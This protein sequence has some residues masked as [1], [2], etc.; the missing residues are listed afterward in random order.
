MG[1]A[2]AN[3]CDACPEGNDSTNVAPDAERPVNAHF[4]LGSGRSLQD[5]RTDS[6]G[7]SMTVN[8]PPLIRPCEIMGKTTHKDS[9][10][11]SE[12]HRFIARYI[13]TVLLALA[14]VVFTAFVSMPLSL[15]R[16]PGEM[17]QVDA[18]PQHMT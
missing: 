3:A 5:Q 8:R 10:M 15:N 7:A 14:P 12:L 4:S 18:P 17:A 16:H 13:G 2:A 9:P 11:N 1:V 6:Q